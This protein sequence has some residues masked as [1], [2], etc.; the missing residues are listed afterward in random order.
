MEECSV[1]KESVEECSCGFID[2][3][4]PPTAQEECEIPLRS[5]TPGAYFVL[6]RNHYSQVEF[7]D[8]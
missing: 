5:Q 6:E 8:S 7:E 2:A 3:E 4:E 1:C